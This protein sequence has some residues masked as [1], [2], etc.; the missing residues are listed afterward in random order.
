MKR[1]KK[2]VE[3]AKNIDRQTLYEAAD[4]ISLV[5]KNATAK[6]DETIEAHIRTGCDGRH[7]EQQIRGAVVLPHGTGK[8]V[9]V[10]V[11]AKGAKAEE[12]EAAGADFVGGEELIPKIQEIQKILFE[13]RE[14]IP[15][16][17]CLL[18]Y[19]KAIGQKRYIEYRRRLSKLLEEHPKLMEKLDLSYF[20]D[21]VLAKVV[22]KY[23]WP[24]GL[25]PQYQD[26]EVMVRYSL[27]HSGEAIEFASKRFQ[28]NR[29]WVKFA[30]EHSANGTIMYL[31]C[32][33]PYRKDKEL[34][35]L[36]CK[37][38]RWNFI[39][40]DKS[41]RDDFELAKLC[42]EQVGN[43]NTIYEYMSARLRGDKE[44]AMLG[45]NY[46]RKWLRYNSTFN[47]FKWI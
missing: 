41:Y 18:P 7:A 33:K 31:D 32:M 22:L 14:F 11:F 6:F 40:V 45:W 47:Y 20:N 15:V 28:N 2:Y 10:L 19:K 34:V 5:K 42:M 25:L 8:T 12:A 4:A 16:E 13:D 27:S 43:L 1:G 29:E 21:R 17:V 9:K 30:I 36:A 35:Y 39:Y 37:V 3:A 26:D 24:L 46:G 38:E 44:L 23:R